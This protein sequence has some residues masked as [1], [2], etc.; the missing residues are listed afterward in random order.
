MKFFRQPLSSDIKK[1]LDDHELK[2]KTKEDIN[3]IVGVYLDYDGYIGDNKLIRVYGNPGCGK[4]LMVKKILD[5]KDYAYIYMQGAETMRVAEETGMME[6]PI[7]A[8]DGELYCGS[9][10][11]N[12]CKEL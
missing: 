4:C 7:I 8:M 9:E 11:V 10:A 5:A 3:S 1:L 12:Y 2:P 6:L